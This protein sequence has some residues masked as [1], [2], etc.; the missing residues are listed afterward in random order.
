MKTASF[1]LW[2]LLTL[3]PLR[4]A[5]WPR[6]FEL[7]E[8]KALA[9][10]ADSHWVQPLLTYAIDSGRS[11][12]LSERWQAKAA[13][14]EAWRYQMLLAQ[15]AIQS[16]T[17]ELAH[18]RL[19][20]VIEL[21]P[22]YAPA[23]LAKAQVALKAGA[24]EAVSLLEKAVGLGASPEPLVDY[25]LEHERKADALAVLEQGWATIPDP[26]L[27][28][29]VVR[30][31]AGVAVR[32]GKFAEV[33]EKLEKSPY[34]EGLAEAYTAVGDHV[35]AASALQRALETRSGDPHL[36]RQALENARARMHT[37]DTIRLLQ[38][39]PASPACTGA[40]FRIL[41]ESLQIREARR[42]IEERGADLAATAAGWMDLAPL[43]WRYDLSP[44]ILQALA[45][46][47]ETWD[48]C[49]ASA[50]LLL[51]E[52]DLAAA[53]EKL[54]KV[55]DPKFDATPLSLEAADLSG[56]REG[57]ALP[58]ENA[59]WM[60]RS[61]R[62]VGEH[63][64]LTERE[65][66]RGWPRLSTLREGR[67]LALFHLA[68]VAIEMDEEKDFIQKLEEQVAALPFGERIFA[69]SVVEH[70]PRL[71]AA[72]EE[73]SQQ[74]ERPS[75]LVTFARSR[76]SILNTMTTLPSA[77]QQQARN[78]QAS[79]SST[80]GRGG[81]SED[82]FAGPRSDWARKA[83]QAHAAFLAGKFPEV[84][85]LMSAAPKTLPM[86][87]SGS[88]NLS[89]YT[90]PLA[91]WIPKFTREDEKAAAATTVLETI[92]FSPR[93]ARSFD[94]LGISAAIWGPQGAAPLQFSGGNSMAF[95]PGPGMGR[96]FRPDMMPPA[97]KGKMIYPAKSLLAPDEANVLWTI[98]GLIREPKVWA[99][100]SREIEAAIQR[101]TP[102]SASHLRLA[103]SYLRWWHGEFD[104]ALAGM[105]SLLAEGGDPD[106][107]FS[108]AAMLRLHGR[109]LEASALLGEMS[110]PYPAFR[111][112]IAAKQVRLAAE[113]KDVATANL[114]LLQLDPALLDRAE[115][116]E[117][118]LFTKGID[119]AA[120]IAPF[121][122]RL[123]RM[124][125]AEQDGRQLELALSDCQGSADKEA[126]ATLAN[127]ILDQ[128]RPRGLS[129]NMYSHQ[130][131]AAL[132]ALR[133][134]EQRA[135][136]VEAMR[137]RLAEEP[138]SAERL[139]R[140]A[141][142][143]GE[144]EEQKKAWQE[145]LK[146]EPQNLHALYAVYEK[147]ER[148]QPER[149]Q[150]FEAMLAI[151]PEEALTLAEGGIVQ[152][153]E[154]LKQLPRFAARIAQARWPKARGPFRLRSF[155]LEQWTNRLSQV[156]EPVMQVAF[157]RAIER[158][159]GFLSTEA[160]RQLVSALQAAGR[161]EEAGK[162]LLDYL[163]GEKGEIPLLLA[164]RDQRRSFGQAL[165]RFD[166]KLL[167]LAQ[168]L[169]VAPELR[170]RIEVRK[171]E[172]QAQQTLLFLRVLER[173]P[174]VL[175]T[176]AGLAELPAEASGFARQ[177][178]A[179]LLQ[180]LLP[181]LISWP[182]AAAVNL[183]LLE[184]VEAWDSNTRNAPGEKMKR[185]L[186]AAELG[187]GEL[188]RKLVLDVLSGAYNQYGQ[189]A[190][191]ARQAAEVAI[192]LKA[193]DLLKSAMESFL[194]T[195]PKTGQPYFDQS[196]AYRFLDLMLQAGYTAEVETLVA[197]LQARLAGTS[198]QPMLARLRQVK[199]EIEAQ[200]GRWEHLVPV[201]W[202]VDART[203]AE[204]V[205]LAWD[206][207][208]EG[209]ESHEAGRLL[210]RGGTVPLWPGECE[211]ELLFGEEANAMRT[212]AR[213]PQAPSRG[214]WQ[215][216]LP[217]EHGYVRAILHKGGQMLFGSPM[218]V[219]ASPNLLQQ[220]GKAKA[221]GLPEQVTGPV[222]GGPSPEGEFYERRPQEN[223]RSSGQDRRNAAARVKVQPGREYQLTGWIRTASD[224][225]AS[226]GLRAFDFNGEEVSIHTGSFYT[227]MS[228]WWTQI[229]VEFGNSGAR[230]DRQGYLP[231]S[232]VSVEPTIE[233]DAFEVA[234]LRLAEAPATNSL[235]SEE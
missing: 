214:M 10:P 142:A 14:P 35:M 230:K 88:T 119:V 73:F 60:T 153:Y 175:Q 9:D 13:E 99:A 129:R 74:A 123:T 100:T 213:L 69:W 143:L 196:Q 161:K 58:M 97:L 127:R 194:G 46:A 117:L 205:T 43:L 45:A 98:Y 187:G 197:A 208:L 102:E 193:P 52:R 170:A 4:A 232:V 85:T 174:A 188:A 181:S 2:L 39:E 201:V 203:S 41:L 108:L 26:Q 190:V 28:R 151:H 91:T 54:W 89:R 189:P 1:L 67:D 173:D 138:N 50:E 15:Q 21:S 195:I 44:P 199:Q 8:E 66:P 179:T 234:D 145:V 226:V 216:K 70:V 231:P 109:P 125:L 107:R 17:P 115:L 23:W 56:P 83:Q 78:V 96:S 198:N 110:V 178:R 217:A 32:Q 200:R 82:R 202:L 136:Y 20:R 160:K 5:E 192:A 165:D 163:T 215:G 167:T 11:A 206:L 140:V 159:N 220:S 34:L 64:S 204:Q 84:L 185:A 228:G 166:P 186:L 6:T 223:A 225:Q 18:E 86:W 118:V 177:E 149:L 57:R 36:R 152:E 63:V 93:P 148:N 116:R 211:V 122:H 172:P 30:K 80:D 90:L 235:V 157:L 81:G 29:Q 92:F 126:I 7:L 141:E 75:S 218:P 135:A 156:G 146:K 106:V 162:V 53:K 12:E 25:Y 40:Q 49:L 27:W 112:L 103:H 128:P 24:P 111:R 134:S 61:N 212:L 55:F 132:Q 71:L 33:L 77:M 79:L 131:S 105:K 94:S 130:R 227:G 37:A 51:R 210:V 121:R 76:L 176:V 209:E 182:E 38:M 158:A 65:G 120:E 124:A 229:S 3:L 222:A 42:L 184:S 101:A 183:K 137:K 31:W 233:G 113:A 22:D 95:P 219:H 147:T 114:G 180:S 68:G 59:S 168:E 62:F 191:H 19:D 224:R 171:D 207:G 133:G 87:S 47:P 154:Q 144:T 72:I 150:L 48:G 169:G 139:F 155:S 16:M 221:W 164:L 104:A